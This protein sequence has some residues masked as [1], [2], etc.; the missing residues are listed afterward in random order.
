[1]RRLLFAPLIILFC[2]L[3]HGQNFEIPAFGTD[4]TF[5]MI[6][7][8][9]EWF[10]KNGQT[11][12]DYVSE[13]I[14]DLEVDLISMQ[15]LDDTIAFKSMLSGM[16]NYEGYFKSGYF[17]G[18]AYIYNFGVLEID[19]IYEIYTTQPYWRP[20]PRSPMVMELRFKGEKFIIINNHFKCCG[21][22]ILDESDDWDEEKRR[23]DA[24]NLLRDY[25]DANF[26]NENV[27]LTGDL[28]DDIAESFSN[29]VFLGFINEPDS[30]LFADMDI[31]NGSTNYWSYPTW[32]SHLDHTLITSATFDEYANEGSGI[33]TLRI[34]DYFS[35]WSSYDANVS[36]HRPVAIK[37]YSDLF[38]GNKELTFQKEYFTCHPNPI[39]GNAKLKFPQVKEDGKAVL[40]FNIHG[41]LVE[42]FN[43]S[44]N[45]TFINWNTS[46]LPGGIYVASLQCWGTIIA[47]N[48]VVILE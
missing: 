27:M 32:P 18:L 13:I 42:K 48:K 24:S 39:S 38:V 12:M 25:I 6:T 45:Q 17:A 30:Y 37:I 43:L 46:S 40:I 47:T 8:N 41:E 3:S 1:M 5:E 26:S 33:E 23:M 14:E 16:N 36:D 35:S 29:N 2:S 10:P 28:N 21:D 7:W 19:S 20:F 31:A 22:G 44:P 9:I 15:E 11:T 4:T 34:D